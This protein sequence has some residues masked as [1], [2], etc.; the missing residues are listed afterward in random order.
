MK[1]RQNSSQDEQ[2]IKKIKKLKRIDL[3]E[4]LLAQSK[5]IDELEEELAEV[6][7]QLMSK[8]IKVREIG[9][10]AEA[11][12]QLNQVFEDA[13]AAAKQ[14]L[15]NIRRLNRMAERRYR[16]EQMPEKMKSEEMK[17]EKNSQKRV[18]KKDEE[19]QVES[20]SVTDDNISE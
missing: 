13:D 18:D 3:L 2:Q 5:K 9:T 10:L 15:Y 1:K 20:G 4:I 8:K 11:S 6:K 14:Y 17:K 7:R 19:N 16:H 12:L